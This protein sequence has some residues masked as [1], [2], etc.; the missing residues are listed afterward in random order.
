MIVL[1]SNSWI[2]K[3]I[4]EKSEFEFIAVDAEVDERAIEAR[5]KNATDIEVCTKI[6]EAKA[7]KVAEKYPDDFVIAADTFGVLPDGARMS[8]PRDEQGALKIAKQQSG[9][10]VRCYTGVTIIYKGKKITG[11]TETELKYVKFSENAVKE[12]MSRSENTVRSGGLGFFMD[13]PGFTLVER[14][15]GSYTGAM[16]LPMEIIRKA[17]KELK[18]EQGRNIS[19][20]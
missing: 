19:K 12:L 7:E 15:T 4:L 9:K 5:T 20:V 1:A 10:T 2:K 8:K 17:I 14:F 3:S 6:A 13:A 18:Y 16:G 11:H